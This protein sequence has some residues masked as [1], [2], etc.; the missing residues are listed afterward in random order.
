MLVISGG[1]LYEELKANGGML[2]EKRVAA[3]IIYPC[4]KALVY[5]HNLV[6]FGL[7]PRSIPVLGRC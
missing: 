5:L 2:P 4:M 1:D 7:R 3:S 6:S